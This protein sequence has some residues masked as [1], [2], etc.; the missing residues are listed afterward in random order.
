MVV[1]LHVRVERISS[2]APFVI[3]DERGWDIGARPQ[4]VEIHT[5]ITAL[6]ARDNIIT[7]IVRAT[8]EDCL[9]STPG[10]WRK[11]TSGEVFPV[12]GSLPRPRSWFMIT[13]GSVIK[14]TAR[15]RYQPMAWTSDTLLQSTC[16]WFDSR[17]VTAP[18][19]TQGIDTSMLVP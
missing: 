9:R 6:Q 17:S 11:G 7:P 14:Q 8:I 1:C 19:P 5:S 10:S 3:V 18:G 4:L 2:C 13:F 15:M 16:M 12:H